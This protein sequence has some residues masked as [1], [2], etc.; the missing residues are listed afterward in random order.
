[1]NLSVCESERSTGSVECRKQFIG[2][3]PPFSEIAVFF[4]VYSLEEGQRDE[5]LSTNIRRKPEEENQIDHR[6]SMCVQ[7][8]SHFQTIK[9]ECV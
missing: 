5:I 6:S 2:F 8:A 3:I 1:M 7:F 4:S 9:N